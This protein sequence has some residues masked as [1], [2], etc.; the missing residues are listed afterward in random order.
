[1]ED[2]RTD[3][4]LKKSDLSTFIAIER[5]YQAKSAI[6]LAAKETTV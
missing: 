1:V 3:G 2:L 6:R 5:H 4:S